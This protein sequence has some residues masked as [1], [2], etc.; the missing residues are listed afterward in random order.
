MHFVRAIGEADRPRM[1]P[2][3]GQREIVADACG[4][5]RLNR[6]VEDTQRHARNDHLD[7]RQL[8]PRRL[9]PHRVHQMCR[10]HR[11]QPSLVDLDARLRD[12]GV[13]LARKLGA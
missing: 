9:V 11:Q 2:H 8:A 4:A 13:A 10:M 6:A 12:I 7:H 3:R 5:V 1:G